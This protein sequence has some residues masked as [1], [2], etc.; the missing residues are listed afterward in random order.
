MVIDCGNGL[1]LFNLQSIHHFQ[2]YW[3]GLE[4]LD[5][6]PAMRQIQHHLSNV[7]RSSGLL[8]SAYVGAGGTHFY[9]PHNSKG[10]LKM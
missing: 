6:G 2:D 5:A 3:T 7:K 4:V 8:L 1:W 9:I 10:H